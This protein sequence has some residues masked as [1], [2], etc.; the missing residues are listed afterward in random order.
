MRLKTK[1]QLFTSLFMLLLI[2]L[3]NASVYYTFNK[4]ST[5]SELDQLSVQ[6]NT[7]I[8]TLNSNPEIPKG[9][10]LEAFLPGNGMIRIY[11]ED[12][13]QPTT[14]FTKQTEYQDL[15]GE[16][17]TKESREIIKRENEANF[18]VISKPIIWSNGEVVTLQVSEQL[19]L[20]E[21]TMTTLAYVLIVASVIMLV[22][23]IIAGI[24]LSR[25]LLRPIRKL[26]QTMKENTRQGNWNK[27]NL[28]NESRDELYEME[29]TFNEMIDQLKDSFEKQAIF[30]SNASHELKT[31]IAIVKSYAQLV[32][33]QGDEHPEVIEESIETID[34]EADRM[35]KLVEQMLTLAESKDTQMEQEIELNQL[36][37]ATVK[38]FK[39]AYEREVLLEYQVNPIYVKGNEA[40]IEQI[41][42]ILI[43]NAIKYSDDQIEVITYTN[44]ENAVLQVIDRGNG[45]SKEEQKHIFSRFYRIDKARGRDTGGTGLGLAIAQTI[46]RA[47]QGD[48][49]VMSKQGEGS[50]F[51]L[52]LPLFINGE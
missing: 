28:Q 42:Y 50:H 21:N 8:E 6:V 23:T 30:V 49:T 32:Q 29:K 34:L 27:I 22:P 36:S 45:I 47:H 38:T 14:V 7:L 10:L 25:F 52:K 35:Q 1:I 44:K 3:I 51:I 17:T 9:D 31:P 33:R 2:L 4:I 39:G 20:L 26:T 16:F 24:V 43:D 13:K 19:D 48:L 41:I 18:A 40:Q 11:Q 15:F 37:A 5:N 12:K 46:A